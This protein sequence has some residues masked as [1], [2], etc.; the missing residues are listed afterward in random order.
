MPSSAEDAGHA[1]HIDVFLGTQTQF[2]TPV[3]QL[4]IEDGNID[5]PDGPGQI[6][7]IFH[8][9]G[10]RP[11]GVKV[12]LCHG[13]RSDPASFIDSQRGQNG[14]QK[15]DPR[16]CVRLIYI[17]RD[18]LGIGAAGH[19][20]RRG[21]KGVATCVPIS[22]VGAIPICAKSLQINSPV[23]LARGSINRVSQKPPLEK[24]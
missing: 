21:K 7:K 22:R 19:Q 2:E 5:P 3:G 11:G 24:W 4:G 17:F 6:D 1:L 10:Q 13:E 14:S 9:L 23:E 20:V 8:M 12:L 15:A 16:R 18:P